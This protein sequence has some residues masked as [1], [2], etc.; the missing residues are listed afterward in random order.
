MIL[1]IFEVSGAVLSFI[2]LTN[3]ENEEHKNADGSYDATYEVVVTATAGL[4]SDTISS[5]AKTFTLAINNIDEPIELAE[6]VLADLGLVSPDP[7]VEGDRDFM[8]ATGDKF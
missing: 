7:V 3:Y 2:G 6:D 4:G 8:Y 5:E 1:Q